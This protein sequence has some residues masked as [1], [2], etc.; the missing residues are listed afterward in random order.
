M[1][2]SNISSD[3]PFDSKFVTVNG[4]KIHY[5]EEG[6]GDVILFLHGMPSWSYLWRNVIPHLS[7]HAR[8]IALDLVGFGRSEQPDIE[9]SVADHI[10]GFISKDKLNWCKENL[11]NLTT[12]DL[13]KGAY[14]YIEDYPHT[15]GKELLNWYKKL[16]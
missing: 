6:Q 10:G 2:D 15:I 3:Y 13:G 1:Y 16:S 8:C 5:I 7:K 12:Y 11:Q 14:W 9:Y 4:S